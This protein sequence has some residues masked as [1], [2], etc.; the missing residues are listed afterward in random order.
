MELASL[1]LEFKERLKEGRKAEA[2]RSKII[3]PSILLN[4][5]ED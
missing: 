2:R 1:V 4:G 5:L 3:K